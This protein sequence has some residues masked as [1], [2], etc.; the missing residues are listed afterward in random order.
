MG[1]INLDDELIPFVIKFGFELQLSKLDDTNRALTPRPF[2]R[3]LYRGAEYDGTK[4][5]L[6]IYKDETLDEVCEK[7]RKVLVQVGEINRNAQIKN[8]LFREEQ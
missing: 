2:V 7:I 5:P 4:V 1:L 6:V 3:F 8:L